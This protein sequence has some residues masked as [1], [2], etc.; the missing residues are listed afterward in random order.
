MV[1][2]NYSVLYINEIVYHIKTC[3]MTEN[4][5]FKSG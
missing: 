4:E 2:N 1:I 5:L 3:M